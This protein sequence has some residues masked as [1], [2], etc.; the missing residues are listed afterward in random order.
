VQRSFGTKHR[1]VVALFILENI[2]DDER[3]VLENIIS[4][5]MTKVFG[6]G[7]RVY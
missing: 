7:E 1:T 4:E 5:Q 6:F 2:W 3:C